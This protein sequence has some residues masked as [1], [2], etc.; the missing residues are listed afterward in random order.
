M[1]KATLETDYLVIGCGAAGMAFTD[2][3]I[4]DSDADVIMVERRH[5]PGG[6]WLNAYP[7]VRLHQP[8][9]YYGVNSLPLGNEQIDSFGPNQG[10]YER[11]SAPE[12]CAYYDRVMQQRLLPSGRVRFF[13]MS[14]VTENRRL[15]SL[16]TGE[17]LDIKVRK[18]V[19]DARY[20]E[21]AI[22][23]T[24][25][26]PFAVSDGVRCIPAGAAA[27]LDERADRYVVIGGGK[28]GI[29]VCL[30]LL[31]CG[32]PPDM[33]QWVKPRELML[34]NRKY[35]QCRELVADLYEGVSLQ[36]EAAAHATSL[37]DLIVRLK[38]AKQFLT[39]DDDVMPNMY[40]GATMSDGEVESLRSITDVVRMGHIQRIDRDEIL[41]EQGRVPT[42]T[43]NLHIHCAACGI[44]P[45]RPK[46]IFTDGLITPQSIRIGLTPFSAALAGYVE[47]TRSTLAEKNAL[48]PSN[49]Q[50]NTPLDWARGTVIGMDAERA[51]GQQ[52]DVRQWLEMSRLNQSAGLE[53][54]RDDPRIMLARDR[55]RQHAKAG[56]GNLMQLVAAGE[57]SHTIA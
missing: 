24:T 42:S 25:P 41:L 54:K 16:L 43:R 32:V 3:L 31:E 37:D 21:A 13:P 56:I 47:A 27:S 38:A 52:A 19:V 5:G 51:W 33:I 2:A 26:P 17:Q 48:C 12:V 22:P 23:A 10:L 18:S 34:H 49:P 1:T 40:R 8:S 29:D 7:F 39:V 6:H 55:L 28:T 36:M 57:S 15:L 50:P 11:A 30:W 46:P 44:S 53:A 14:E 45:V 35:L 20:L 4:S 9:A